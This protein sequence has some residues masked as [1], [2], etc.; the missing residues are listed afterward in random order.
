MND[1]FF[2]ERYTLMR[3]R[4][5]E[6]QKEEIVK[7]PYGEYFRKTAEFILMVD[8]LHDKIQKGWLNN[9]SQKELEENNHALYQ[10]ILP[11]NYG[12]S[13]GNPAY[14]Q[15]VLGEEFGPLL[16][17]LYTEIRGMIVFAYE[18]RLFDMTVVL[19][20]FVQIY[21]LFEEEEVSAK[22]VKDAIY[23]YISDYS[24]EMVGY[25]VREGIDS[26]LDF[27]VKIICDSDLTDLRYLYKFGEYITEN[28]IGMANFLNT[29][30]EEKIQAM[31]RTFT[32]GYREGFVLGG[33]DITKKKTVNI[34]FQ[35]GF[36]R[37]VKE[38]IRQFAEMGLQ[39]VVYRS[40]VHSVN[41]KQHHR[42]GYYGAVP[43]QQFEYDHKDD[44]ALYLD[45]EFV[46]R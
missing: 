9:A 4:I 6:I 15:S 17:F 21:N 14:A 29:L 39:P 1:V 8:R 35:L 24:D 33:K 13:Y 11:E 32:E 46:Q 3:E 12:T 38:E 2:E 36:E 30:P 16:S 25:R 28:E 5:Q 18:K 45:H 20:L 7:E 42:I 34:R 43:N 41:K 19:E 44:A 22:D 27:A 31:A 10:D 37:I 26:S 40:A 23:W